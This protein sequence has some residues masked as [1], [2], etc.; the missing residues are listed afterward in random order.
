MPQTN[1]ISQPINALAPVEAPHARQPVKVELRGVAKTY[2]TGSKR[3]MALRGIDLTIHEGEF[4]AIVGPSGCGKSTLL[5][6]IA[7]FETPDEGQVLFEGKPVAGSGPDRLVLFQEHGLFPW[8]TVGQ[9]VEFG[10]RVRGLSKPA[11]RERAEHYLKMVHLQK[12]RRSYPFQLSGGMKQRAAIARAL[13]VE[14][15]MFLMDE[16]FSS[17]D[18]RTR[19]ILHLELQ[20]LWMETRK[21]IVF[22]THSVEEATRLADRIIVMASQPGRIRKTLNVALPHPRD[23]LDPALVELRALILNELSDELD[24]LV[25]KEGDDDWVLEEKSIGARARG[26]VDLD[27]GDGI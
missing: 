15:S 5:N 25:K 21:T 8:L 11:R 6:L 1:L 14:P 18:P 3:F 13:A 12:F 20:S 7:G 4:L 10:L 27:M 19:D 23:F 9:N 17:L 24:K 2:T 26:D 16:P 22:V